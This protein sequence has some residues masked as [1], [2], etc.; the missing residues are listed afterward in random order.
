M[1]DWVSAILPC[2]DVTKITDGSM[3][4]VDSDRQIG[5]YSIISIQLSIHLF[6]Q[7][8][9]DYAESIRSIL[10]KGPHSANQLIDILNISQPTLSRALVGMGNEIIRLGAA[11]SIQYSLRDTSRGLPEM[12]IYR[13]NSEGQLHLLGTLIPVKSEGFV[14]REEGGGQLYSHGLPWWLF[15]MRPQGY[16]GRSYAAKYG[17]AL[18]NPIRL[19]DWNDT[20]ALRA[21]IVHGEDVIGNILIGN[22]VRERFLARPIPTPIRDEQKSECYIKLAHDAANGDVPGSSAGGEQPKFTV[23]AMT[24]RGDCHVLVKFSES[25]QGPVSERWRDLLLAEHMALDVLR[26]HGIPAAHTNIIDV[27]QQRFLEIERFDRVSP[28]GRRGIISLAAMD[29]EF[30]GMGNGGWPTMVEALAKDRHITT[31]AAEVA[32]MLWAFGTLIGNTDMHTGNLS[33]VAENGRPYEIAP[34][35]DMTPMAFAPRQGGGIPDVLREARLEANVSNAVWRQAREIAH[36][37]LAR[38]INEPR[39]SQ[40]F[41][42][43]ILALREHI[44]TASRK[45]DRLA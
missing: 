44:E 25:E 17:E 38:L 27:G 2:H 35:Y 14:M 18:G 12:P 30:V 22:T 32:K 5:K 29:A 26:Q 37:Y 23:Y 6:I 41:Q 7:T 16:L 43:C 20:H 24:A 39:F 36:Q 40:R 9:R 34:A 21:L 31:Q 19:V 15:D 42:P 1:I 45:I 4:V 28:L 11:R 10:A 8:M 33:F 3:T 13:V